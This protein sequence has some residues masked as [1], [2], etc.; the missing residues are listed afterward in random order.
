MF[1]IPLIVAYDTCP[2][3]KL[4]FTLLFTDSCDINGNNGYRK[5]RSTK[6]TPP[7]SPHFSVSKKSS[8]HSQ[9]THG[10]NNNTYH[11][12]TCK[13]SPKQSHTKPL[14][15]KDVESQRSKIG[16]DHRKPK[17]I[18]TKESKPWKHLPDIKSRMAG[19]ATPNLVKH[20]EKEIGSTKCEPFISDE[21]LADLLGDVPILTA[22]TVVSDKADENATR[23][24]WDS[25]ITET[26]CRSDKTWEYSECTSTRPKIR[27]NTADTIHLLSHTVLPHSDIPLSAHLE[28]DVMNSEGAEAKNWGSDYDMLEQSLAS[29]KFCEDI[30]ED[31]VQGSRF[32]PLFR[33]N[34]FC[35]MMKHGTHSSSDAENS[36]RTDAFTCRHCEETYEIVLETEAKTTPKYYSNLFNHI[37]SRLDFDWTKY[38]PPPWASVDD[39]SERTKCSK[40]S[41]GCD[42]DFCRS[43]IWRQSCKWCGTPK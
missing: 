2:L 6:H 13:R 37:D 33:E 28:T 5:V 39:Q 17:H 23:A 40:L 21:I 31:G 10:N 1:I 43:R 16:Q 14:K 3:S 26:Q 36:V 18:K 41:N 9:S 12:K 38:H 34:P 29:L 8:G 22:E 19:S 30:E 7:H 32:A 35:Y 24:F 42:C 27:A 11:G 4:L 25:D 20:I 15:R